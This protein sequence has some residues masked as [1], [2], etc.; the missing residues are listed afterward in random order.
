MACG[1]PVV[2]TDYPGARA[3]VSDG[4][5]GLIVPTGDVP[6]VAAAL[7]RLAGLEPDALSRMS[8]RGRAKTIER[9]SWPRL[10]E[11]SEEIYAEAIDRRRRRLGPTR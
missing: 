5:D 6:A 10:A 9:Y 4:E 7:D 2:A 11:R 3:V 1:L 8:E